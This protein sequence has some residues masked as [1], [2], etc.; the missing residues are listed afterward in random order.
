MLEIL[1]NP[2]SR[3]NFHENDDSIQIYEKIPFMEKQKRKKRKGRN[4]IRRRN[5][6]MPRF[7][8]WLVS[9]SATRF[10]SLAPLFK[11]NPVNN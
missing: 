1:L 3:A 5:E 9:M 10:W 2:R 4:N 6:T 8:F 11:N 7:L